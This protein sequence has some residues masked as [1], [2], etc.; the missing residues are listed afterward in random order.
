MILIVVGIIVFLISLVL[1]R[2]WW[3]AGFWSGGYG[4]P[5]APGGVVRANGC[6]APAVRRTTYGQ[7]R[8]AS[9]D[10]LPAPVATEYGFRNRNAASA[11]CALV[12]Q[13][14]AT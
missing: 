1:W 9:A 5:A 10:R 7:G 14:S 3:G 2:T 13:L 4:D 6:T 11:R 12:R 8:A